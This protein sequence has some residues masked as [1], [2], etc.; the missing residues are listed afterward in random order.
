[1]DGAQD[2][3]STLRH[4]PIRR[5]DRAR[6][7]SLVPVVS[8]F[9]LVEADLLAA[10]QPQRTSKGFAFGL[11]RRFQLLRDTHPTTCAFQMQSR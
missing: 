3:P 11:H 2:L 7:P 5:F 8:M 9:E 10:L 6:H 4:E 1:M